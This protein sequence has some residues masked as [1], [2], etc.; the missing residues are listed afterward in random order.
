MGLLAINFLPSLR[1]FPPYAQRYRSVAVANA[2]LVR[3]LDAKVDANLAPGVDDNFA[4]LSARAEGEGFDREQ[5]AYT[6]RECISA[7]T[8]T[9]ATT[10]LWALVLLADHP[11]VQ[12]RMHEEMKEVLGE[13][14]EGGVE[15][16]EEGVE[17]RLPGLADR[18]RLRYAEAV[19]L[20]VMRCKTIAPLSVPHATLRDTEVC[21]CN[22]PAG[23]MVSVRE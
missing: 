8:E 6:L 18:G 22:V 23:T 20:E 2:D 13:K 16:G 7:G 5:L 14:G 1:W 15:K 3:L 12:Q 21:G 11:H 4:S 19:M 10:L 9:S 17:G